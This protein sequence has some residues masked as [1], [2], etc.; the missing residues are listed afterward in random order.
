MVPAPP[1]RRL[2]LLVTGTD[3]GVGKT[4]VGCLLA[5]RLA[6]EGFSVIPLKPVESGCSPGPDGKPFPADAAALRAA[7]ASSLPL[8][9]VCLYPLSA[10][11]SPHLAARREATSIDIGRIRGAVEDAAVKSDVVLVEGAGG[12]SVEIVEGYSFADLARESSMAVLVVAGNRLGVL[13]HV[14]LTIRYLESEGIPLFGVVLS[15]LPADPSPAREANEDEVRRIAGER[16]LG[17]I[18]RGAAVLPGELF[19]RFL[20]L[21]LTR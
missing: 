14:R 2:R 6:A 10:P 4:Y 9:A 16:Y 20:E 8:D 15:D 1:G 19:S 21:G 11:L 12:I 18:S 17:R 5:R 13:N 3:T 7:A